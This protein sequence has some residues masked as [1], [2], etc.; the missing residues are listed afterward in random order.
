MDHTELRRFAMS[1]VLVLDPIIAEAEKPSHRRLRQT[2]RGLAWLFS[3]IFA[4][5]VS[6]IAAGIIVAF[7]F[8]SHVQ[9]NAEGANFSFGLNGQLPRSIP[10]MV[11]LSDQPFITR[12]AGVI[13]LAIA[14]LSFLLIFWNLRGLFGL[15]ASGI[16][17][18][19]ENAAYLKFVGVWLIAYLPLKL[20]AN[21][22]FRLAGGV[23]HNWLHMDGVEA[24]VLGI[25][26]V[27]IAQVM[28]FGHE[29]EQEKDSFI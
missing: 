18:A 20:I 25:I 9:M 16:V 24:L 13:D 15:Y 10:G 17:F 3:A 6:Y 28:E 21:V 14:S 19:R 11:R 2:S 8:S 26:V 4:L 22:V 23:D 7:F 27:A 29:I 5:Y 12:L 1:N